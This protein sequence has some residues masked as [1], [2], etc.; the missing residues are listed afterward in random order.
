MKR[1]MNEVG[2]G[3]TYDTTFTRIRERQNGARILVCTC[4]LVKGENNIPCRP[5][6]DVFAFKRMDVL[7]VLRVGKLWGKYVVSM[8]SWSRR[9]VE[10]VK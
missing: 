5:V 8:I 2:Y 6:H 1:K 9:Q 7:V 4:N 3:A 10:E